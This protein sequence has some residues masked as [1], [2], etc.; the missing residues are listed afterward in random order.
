[1]E[2][3]KKDPAPTPEVNVS[4]STYPVIVEPPDMQVMRTKIGFEVLFV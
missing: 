4:P 2:A 3:L 1:V